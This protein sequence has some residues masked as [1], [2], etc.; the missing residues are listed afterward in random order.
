MDSAARAERDRREN[1]TIATGTRGDTAGAH[2][3]SR[4]EREGVVKELR[5]VARVCLPV[6]GP[7]VDPSYM[8]RKQEKKNL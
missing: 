6:G 3:R 5:V 2:S 8:P 7:I 4:D 1:T